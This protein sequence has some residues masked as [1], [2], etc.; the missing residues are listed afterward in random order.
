MADCIW[1]LFGVVSQ[2]DAR[3]FGV[4]VSSSVNKMMLMSLDEYFSPTTTVPWLS[5]AWQFT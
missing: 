1:M 5:H 2:V 4:G 3:M